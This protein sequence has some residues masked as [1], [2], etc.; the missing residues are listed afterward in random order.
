M[1]HE[2]RFWNVCREA[3]ED[4]GW[5]LA[6]WPTVTVLRGAVVYRDHGAVGPAQGRP[7]SFG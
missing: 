3:C 2:E 1:A 4:E 7:L 6:G 5:E